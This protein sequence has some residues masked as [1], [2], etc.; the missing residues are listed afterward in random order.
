M[1]LR[2]RA[3]V[4]TASPSNP[5]PYPPQYTSGAPPSQ[6]EPPDRTPMWITLLVILLLVI[7]GLV[8]LLVNDRGDPSQVA[9]PQGTSDARLRVPNVVGL[10]FAEAERE[11]ADV[12]FSHVTIEFSERDDVD[13]NMV[14]QQNP[15]AGLL[16]AEPQRS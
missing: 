1:A 4:S 6:I 7:A 14:F 3:P 15:R 16:L 12:G 2:A 10:H 5:Q 8:F 11:L 13:E 9:E